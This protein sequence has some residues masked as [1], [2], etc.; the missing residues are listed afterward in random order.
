MSLSVAKN[1]RRTC[2]L[3]DV[4]TNATRGLLMKHARLLILFA[5]IALPACTAARLSNDEAQKKIAAIGQ[6]NLVPD[7]IEIR[8]IVS[9]SDT[10]AIAGS[11]V[12]LAF[13][14]RRPNSNAEW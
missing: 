7:G 6:S 12:T 9:Q 2:I 13:E 14:F 11:T 1:R 8:R 10:S 3:L 4:S 5:S